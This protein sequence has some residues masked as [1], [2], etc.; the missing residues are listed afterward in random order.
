MSTPLH[1]DFEYFLAHQDELVAKYEGRVVVIK[2]R[3]VLGDYPSEQAAIAETSK[4]HPIGSF[5]V[6]FV[7]RGEAAYTQTFFSRVRIPA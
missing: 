2:D 7:G 5:L 6:Q 1:A 3:V 4:V